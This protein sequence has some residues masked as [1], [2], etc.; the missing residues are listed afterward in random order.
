MSVGDMEWQI[1]HT[2]HS[3]GL[4]GKI[5]VYTQHTA[6]NCTSHSSNG[7]YMGVNLSPIRDAINANGMFP[8]LYIYINKAKRARDAEIERR[9]IPRASWPFLAY[10]SRIASTPIRM[11]IWFLSHDSMCEHV[12]YCILFDTYRCKYVCHVAG[13]FTTPPTTPH[14]AIH[15]TFALLDQKLIQNIVCGSI[16]FS[17]C[18][19]Q[20]D[21]TPILFH[22]LHQ[23]GIFV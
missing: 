14:H 17:K 8:Y 16:N 13:Y 2:L 19:L 4:F 15:V 10:V 9:V 1:T 12:V 6:H 7:Y 11:A 23:F 18:T 3:L 22:H 21:H 5:Y 20:S